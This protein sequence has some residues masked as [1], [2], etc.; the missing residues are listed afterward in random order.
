[1]GGREGEYEIKEREDKECHTKERK[2]S[3]GERDEDDGKSEG[4][5]I[6]IKKNGMY[7]TV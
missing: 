2:N 7:I 6:N 5:K 3:H 4:K 1:M